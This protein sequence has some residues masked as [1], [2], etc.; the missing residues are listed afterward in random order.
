MSGWRTPF[1]ITVVAILVV[2]VAMVALGMGPEVLLVAAVG[3]C[4]G[5]AVW[6]LHP[7]LETAAPE[8]PPAAVAAVPPPGADHRVKRLRSG[9]V[10]SSGM[11]VYAERLYLNLVE[12]IDDQL[13]HAHGIDRRTAPADAEAVIGTELH[14]FVEDPEA[15]KALSR[16]R[17]L[18]RIVTLIEQI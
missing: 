17:D 6:C 4:V 15:A 8:P 9:I 14:R 11:D 18:D 13:V 2:E 3:A 10:F 16:P 12:L 7:L 1:V 5:S